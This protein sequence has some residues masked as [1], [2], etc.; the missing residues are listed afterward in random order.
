[1]Q[2]NLDMVQHVMDV[3][4][5]ATGWAHVVCLGEYLPCHPS[6]FP[7]TLLPCP[8]SGVVPLAAPQQLPTGLYAQPSHNTTFCVNSL[9][10]LMVFL[11]SHSQCPGPLFPHRPPPQK[12]GPVPLAALQQVCPVPQACMH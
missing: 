6:F 12:T 9:P 5:C 2:A 4:V 1:M 10:H 7:P 8:K 11:H 3:L